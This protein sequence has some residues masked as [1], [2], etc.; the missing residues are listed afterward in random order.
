[1]SD[2]LP[3]ETPT[4]SDSTSSDDS[5]MLIL[6]LTYMRKIGTVWMHRLLLYDL[7]FDCSIYAYD[8]I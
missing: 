1:M 3:I 8:F 7:A 4:D 2:S 5:G 6:T